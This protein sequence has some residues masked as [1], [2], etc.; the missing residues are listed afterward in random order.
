ML[1]QIPQKREPF[2]MK[3]RLNVIMLR[4]ELDMIAITSNE[5]KAK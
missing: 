4:D 5:A 2:V 3:E 1:L